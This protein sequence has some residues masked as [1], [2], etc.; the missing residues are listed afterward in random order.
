MTRNRIEQF[1]H[2]LGHEKLLAER[3]KPLNVTSTFVRFLR[4]TS[5]ALGQIARYYCSDEKRK[6]RQPVLRIGNRELPDRR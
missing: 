6:Q 1:D 4:L 5:H 3:I 2:V